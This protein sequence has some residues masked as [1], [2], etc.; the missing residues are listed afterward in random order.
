MAAASLSFCNLKFFA[1][2]LLGLAIIIMTINSTEGKKVAT[3]QANRN[4]EH[5]L[6]LI[7]Y[8]FLT[9]TWPFKGH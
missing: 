7:L 8:K 9:D 5:R 4:H 3:L 2:L 6:L 1:S